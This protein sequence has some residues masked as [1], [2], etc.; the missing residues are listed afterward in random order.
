MLVCTACEGKGR[1]KNPGQPS[2]EC[3]LCDGAGVL[4][5]PQ[6]ERLIQAVEKVAKEL[7]ELR[8]IA[9]RFERQRGR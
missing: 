8:R 5:D 1:I 7:E 9:E 3:L 4:E 2:E 6:L